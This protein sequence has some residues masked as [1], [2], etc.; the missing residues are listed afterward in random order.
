MAISVSWT[1]RIPLREAASRVRSL[2][3]N[4][5]K[6][7]T[8][9]RHSYGHERGTF[10]MFTEGARIEVG[11]FC[12]IS[13]EVRILGGGEHVRT[14][15]STFPFNA[16]M[17]DPS[18]RT[19]PDAI[20]A[21]ATRIGNDVWLGFGALV[22]PG[23]TIGDGAIVGAG[24][25]VRESVPPYAIVVGN[26]AHVARYRFPPEIRERILA[27]QW[28]AWDD[29]LIRARERW[30]MGDVETFLENAERSAAADGE[31]ASG[32]TLGSRRLEPIARLARP[33]AGW[34]Q[35]R[36]ARRNRSRLPI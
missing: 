12:S 13:P 6:G 20:D 26:P 2:F 1:Q 30:F 18:R 7:V 25:V 5:P 3:R 31:P 34:R 32:L 27:V 19:G 21:G 24:A 10:P 33:P 4:L 9:G 36:R 8:V 17:F 23:V 29:M 14:R 35:A 16:R 28:W 11:A 22:L 15:A